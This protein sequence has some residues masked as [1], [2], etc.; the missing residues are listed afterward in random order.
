VP[1]L[2]YRPE[3]WLFTFVLTVVYPIVDAFLYARLKS[4]IPIYLWNILAAWALTIAAAWLI[5]SNG[6]TL[7]DVGQNLGAYPRTLIVSAILIVLVVALVLQNRWQKKKA[8]PEKIAQAV[9]NIRKLLPVTGRERALW[10]VV[11][12]TTGFCEEFLYRGWLFNISGSALKS[13][14]LGLLVSSVFFG[15]GHLYQGRTGMLS[16]GVLGLVFGLIYIASR[17]LLPGQILHTLLDL[18]NGLVFG[19]IASRAQPAT[20]STP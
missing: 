6:L 12:F 11:A 13:V 16:T 20:E 9:E 5:L 3:T 18:S 2:L 1:A 14:W 15:F 4:A 8:G 10:I 17:S 7:A 19:R